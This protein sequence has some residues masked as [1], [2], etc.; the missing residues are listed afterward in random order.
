MKNIKSTKKLL[1]VIAAALL[2]VA[3]PAIAVEITS[4]KS[5]VNAY[6][7]F[8]DKYDKLAGQEHVF[9][10]A[11]F[12]QIYHYFLGGVHNGT[13]N[14][15]ASLG[16]DDKGAD[17]WSNRRGYEV[18]VKSGNHI[19]LLGGTWSPELQAAIGHINDM[20][21]E[22]G[23]TAVYNFDPH[24]DGRAESGIDIFA[25]PG[26]E[27]D[28][29]TTEEFTTKVYYRQRGDALATALLTYNDGVDPAGRVSADELKIPS[30]II[31]NKDNA[32]APV[33]AQYTWDS[34]VAADEATFKTGLRAA[35]DKIATGEPKK[36]ANVVNVA[37][38]DYSLE[39]LNAR[40]R[41]FFK[42]SRI[43]LLTVDGQPIMVDGVA[44]QGRNLTLF[45]E[46]DR[47]TPLEIV[48]YEELLGALASP[49]NHAFV[50]AGQWCPNTY[51]NLRDIHDYAIEY[52]VGK[53]YFFDPELDATFNN[54]ITAIRNS[55]RTFISGLYIDLMQNV[56]T[57]V[58]PHGIPTQ[59]DDAYENYLL[60]ENARRAEKG[61]ALLT[62]EE[63][64][65]IRLTNAG[66]SG[67]GYSIYEKQPGSTDKG[68]APVEN[69]KWVARLGQPALAL[70]NKDHR[71]TAGKPAPVISLFQQMWFSGGNLSAPGTFGYAASRQGRVVEF[72]EYVYRD[73][74]Q[75]DTLHN[76]GIYDAMK[77]Q[78]IPKTSVVE[79]SANGKTGGADSRGVNTPVTSRAY[80]QG[81]NE[82]FNAFGVTVL[83]D[84]IAQAEGASAD[85]YSIEEYATLKAALEAAKTVVDDIKAADAAAKAADLAK[86]NAPVSASRSDVS[87]ARLTIVEQVGSFTNRSA[88]IKAACGTLE[89]ALAKARGF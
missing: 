84:L 9:Q 59:Y 78:P 85:N 35:F 69:A 51:A 57:N 50:F 40:F 10:T 53:V 39:N 23:V 82:V 37:P 38:S 80:W 79:Y 76:L 47:W 25:A 22:Y 30:I 54:S 81:L 70:Y 65:Q 67:D 87:K 41:D 34:A 32:G 16:K 8:S 18:N 61:Q 89:T 64:L 73:G 52:N 33:V 62:E 15:W 1:A 66:N 2:L 77:N 74:R 72:Q 7:F 48:T 83:E 6:D 11:E 58:G 44:Q 4:A 29:G 56:L 21:K 26:R 27:S 71:D 24:L 14:F 49:G 19:F 46:A 86:V 3:A 36:A 88:E 60:S 63:K 68:H 45:T 12:G 13:F 31:W 17:K 75:P 28:Y 20:A 55:D 5:F 42:N 43:P